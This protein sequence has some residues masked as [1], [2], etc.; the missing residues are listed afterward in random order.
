MVGA[1]ALAAVTIIAAGLVDFPLAVADGPS[2]APGVAEV[3]QPKRPVRY[4]R[5]KPGQEAPKGAKVIEEAAPAPRV[6]IQRIV[7]RA[8]GGSTRPV[9]R[10]RQSGR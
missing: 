1:S 6:V 5:L 4:V 2:P 3:E 9:A 8:Q 7:T 10:S